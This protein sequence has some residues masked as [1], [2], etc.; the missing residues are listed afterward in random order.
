[1]VRVPRTETADESSQTITVVEK[2]DTT[3]K[4]AK[5]INPSQASSIP[6]PTSSLSRVTAVLSTRDLSG[7]KLTLPILLDCGCSTSLLSVDAARKIGARIDVA[8]KVMLYNASGENMKISGQSIIK[9]DIPSLS[10]TAF[11]NFLVTP[12]LPRSKQVMLGLR[13]FEALCLIPRDWPRNL[14]FNVEEMEVESE[15][16]PPVE[17]VQSHQDKTEQCSP[18]QS[19]S[20]K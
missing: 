4:K 12:D 8:K 11:L 14:W 2:M 9:V 17:D 10:K 6:L 5:S 1:M 20:T 3:G 13:A 16:P 19:S 18:G 15:A 7:K